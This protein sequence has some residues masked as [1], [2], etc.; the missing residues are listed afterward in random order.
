MKMTKHQ[1]LIAERALL[2]SLIIDISIFKKILDERIDRNDFYKEEYGIIFD[3]LKGLF[4]SSKQSDTSAL[5]IKINQFEKIKEVDGQ[6][7]LS[8]IMGCEADSSNVLN[9]VLEIKKKSILRFIRKKTLVGSEKCQNFKGD[10]EKLEKLIHEIQMA[11]AKPAIELN[12]NELIPLSKGLKANLKRMEDSSRVGDIQGVPTGFKILDK[13]L[14]GMQEGKHYVLGGRP[15]MGKTTLTVNFV[16]NAAE[17]AKLPIAYFTISETANEITSRFISQKGSLENIKMKTREFSEDDLNK[18]AAAVKDLS[19]LPI[20]I[21]DTG[22]LT[23]A[24]MRASCAKLKIE[25]GLALV[26]LD[27]YQ[28]LNSTDSDPR[29]IARDLKDLAVELNCPVLVLSQ[30]SRK[31][32]DRKN[33][34]PQIR[35]LRKCGGIEDFADGICFLYRD[36]YYHYDT[37]EEKGVGEIIIGKNRNGETGVVKLKFDGTIPNFVEF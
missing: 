31:L 23:V 34:R 2:Q 22:N 28:L 12:Q 26:V 19:E 7:L 17:H 18:F 4:F 33:K 3:A 15:A 16:I 1:N 21:E 30:L 9:Y 14:L 10:M 37:T 8:E 27:Y 5:L 32:E 6:E 25:K 20:Y 29:K 36:E 24:K 35:D 13:I 11:F